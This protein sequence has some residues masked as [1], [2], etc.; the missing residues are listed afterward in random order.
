M[1]IFQIIHLNRGEADRKQKLMDTLLIHNV[2]CFG[3][4]PHLL[5]LD[6]NPERA[7][8]GYNPKVFQEPDVKKAMRT[9]GAQILKF[10]ARAF[11]AIKPFL[12]Q[13]YLFKKETKS[14]LFYRSKTQPAKF[15]I[16][17]NGVIKS[18]K[19]MLDIML[20]H[21]LVAICYES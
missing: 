12:D 4:G 15:L 7:N 5:I 9:C 6:E 16:F 21:Q 3:S 17:K 19:D 8:Q 10:D 11:K 20:I 18:T 2:T 1:K 13:H 14:A